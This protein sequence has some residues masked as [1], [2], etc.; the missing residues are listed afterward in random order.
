[1]ANSAG[2]AAES[3]DLS[4][5]GDGVQSRPF[6]PLNSVLMDSSIVAQLFRQLFSQ[7][8]VGCVRLRHSLERHG[9]NVCRTQ[10]RTLYG[11]SRSKSA[12]QQAP[13]WKQR[14]ETFPED[15]SEEFKR[16]PMVTADEL[17][18]RRDRPKRVKMLL[19][20]FIEGAFTTLGF[21]ILQAELAGQTVYT[22]HIMAIFRSMQPYSPPVTVSISTASKTNRSSTDC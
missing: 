1:M 12:G 14:M 15:R 19:R 18:H 6:Q 13:A 2:R 4:S 11:V 16:Y 9:T 5:R 10:R 8:A 7:R 17:R 22:T 20:D 21:E 3:S